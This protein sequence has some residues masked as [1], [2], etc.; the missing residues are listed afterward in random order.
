MKKEDLRDILIHNNLK[1]TPQRL[2]VLD[3]VKHLKDHPTADK[4]TA[5]VRKNHPN[6]AQGTVYKILLTFVEKG[7]VKKVKTDRD[8]MRF[9]PILEKHHHLYCYESDRIEDYYDKDLN[10]MLEKYFE[11][12]NIPDFS[13]D[14]IKLQIIGKFHNRKKE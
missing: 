2:V 10:N 4:I 14:D 7:I 9:D 3:A 13:I 11:K 12:K 5:Y 8:F 1:I 6:I